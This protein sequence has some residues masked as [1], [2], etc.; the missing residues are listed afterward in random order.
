MK[1]VSR[2]AVVVHTMTLRRRLVIALL[3]LM[4]VGFAL[5]AAATAVALH[6]FLLSRLD[7]ELLAAGDRYS[8]S[9]EHPG[10]G[11]ADNRVQFG[12]VTGQSTGT[13]GARTV[14][15]TVTAAQVVGRSTPLGSEARAALA[16]VSVSSRP[17]EIHLSDV[18]DYR[19][20]AVR[21]DDGD[22]LITGLPLEPVDDTI[23]SLLGIEAVVFAAV[24][25]LVGVGGAL[26]VR[27]TLLPLNR[28]ADTALRVSDLPLS[29]GAVSLPE[30]AAEAPPGTEAGT[31][32]AAFN[33]MLEHVESALHERQASEERLRRFIADASHE[34]RTPVA[35]VRSHAEYAQRVQDDLPGP[36]QQSLSR[37]AAES[38]RMGHLVEDLLLLARLDSGRPLAAEPVDLT[39]VVLDAVGDARIAGPDHRWQLDLPAEPV[40]VVGDRDALHQVVANLLANALVHTPGRT[41]VRTAVRPSG[42]GEAPGSVELSVSDD[43]PGLSPE[44][45]PKVFERF[46]HGADARSATTGSSGLGLAIV[47]AIVHAHKGV[48]D[49]RTGPGGVGC[50]VRVVLPVA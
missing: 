42:P 4:A 15:G 21:G 19:I 30:R 3:A 47:A 5:V 14:N 35:V 13:L 46:A 16:R 50:D 31:V 12:T 17:H 48:V 18:G 37:I 20:I 39:R 9:L 49:L 43:G 6:R 33:H 27:L 10:D 38:E 23:H 44:L 1:L 40:V 28:L 41:T 34:L 11:D 25:V 26:F 7:Q 8:I 2:F 32:S 24:L 45:V 29:S 22:V 36:I